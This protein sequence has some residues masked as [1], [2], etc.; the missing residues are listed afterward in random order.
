MK[1]VLVL[2][3]FIFC[4][5]AVGLGCQSSSNAV[6]GAN[7]SAKPESTPA[8]SANISGTQTVKIESPDKV[9]IIGTFYEAEK[10]NSPALLLLHQWQS[11]RH[12]YDD[13]AKRM[14]AK[15]FAVLSIDGRGFG[16]SIK[17]ADGKTV[18]PER[19]DAAVKGMLSDVG[20]AFDLLSKRKNVDAG[21]IGIVGASYGSSLALIYS[22]ENPKVA[23]AAL[24]S[25]GLNYFGNMQTEPAIKKFGNRPLLLVAA[26]DDAESADSI[27]K[28][29][30]ASANEKYESHIY[31][32]GGHGTG[33]FRANV[34]LED[35][36]EG[37]FT[38]DLS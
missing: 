12:S 37:F 29:K 11:D 15:G 32:I 4:V 19:T 21:R 30:G 33:L 2:C 26:S 31:P 7:N 22:A 6:A 16:E 9:E 13:F 17:M 1:I 23:A 28:L 36:L 20:A 18:G 27:K 24:L 5:I 8:K 34:G 3:V 35:M 25:P 14:Q 38:K 10:P